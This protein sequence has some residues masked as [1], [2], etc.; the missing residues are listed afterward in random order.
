MQAVS[1]SEARG[2]LEMWVPHPWNQAQDVA[3]N[4]KGKGFSTAPTP[5]PGSQG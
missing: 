2:G 3:S 1:G 4:P 5:H